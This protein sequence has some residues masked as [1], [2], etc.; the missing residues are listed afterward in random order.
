FENPSIAALMN[1]H[2]VCIKVDREERPDLDD[3]YMA[4]TLAMSGHGGWPMTVFLTPDQRP[5]FAG[6][7]FP[8]EN[9]YGRIGFATLLTRIAEVWRED[10]DGIE[11]QAEQLTHAVRE[12]LSGLARGAVS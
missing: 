7:Y 1:A 10:R 6:T 9:R 2:F 5:F 3:I 8:P 12:Q 4:A 11:Q